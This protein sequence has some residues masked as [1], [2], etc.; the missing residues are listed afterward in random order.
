MKYFLIINPRSRSERS[1]RDV[2]KI[3]ERFTK[4]GVDFD[5]VFASSYQSIRAESEYANRQGYDF[6]VAVGGDGTINASING[7][8]D[9]NGRRISHARFGVVYTGTSPDFCKSYGIPLDRVKAIDLLF[10]PRIRHIRTGRIQFRTIANREVT[11]TR[12]FACCANIGLG[13]GVADISNKIRKYTGD[14]A[15][16]LLAILWN[17]MAAGSGRLMVSIDEIKSDIPRVLNISAGRTKFIA[18]GIRVS[19]GI[20]DDDDRF[21]VLTAKNITLRALPRL[22]HEVYT[23]KFISPETLEFRFAERLEF[24]S[25]DRP[26]GVEFDGDAAGYLPCTINLAPDPLDLMTGQ[27]TISTNP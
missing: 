11:E 25:P 15:G 8:Y 5:H 12:V 26:V 10:D 18:S 20:P 24:L 23:G 27:I 7:F 2:K 1:H 14:F 22:L 21:Y 6:I 4:K 16:T 19:D 13:A 9:E 17:L 3:L